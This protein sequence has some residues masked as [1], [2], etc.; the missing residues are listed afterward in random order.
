MRR[1]RSTAKIVHGLV[2][3]PPLTPATDEPSPHTGV[4]LVGKIGVVA[5]LFCQPV[6]RAAAPLPEKLTAWR[7]MV[8]VPGVATPP[9]TVVAAVGTAGAPSK[10]PRPMNDCWA[11]CEYMMVN[12]PRTTNLLLPKTSQAI[13][14]RGA[15]S[16]WSPL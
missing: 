3:K 15:K 4:T 11:I 9:T 7:L 12:P 5:L 13:P 16:L 8:P 10:L 6:A 1:L 14:R 2:A